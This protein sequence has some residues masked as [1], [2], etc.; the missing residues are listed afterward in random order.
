MILFAGFHIL[1]ILH[2]SYSSLSSKSCPADF[3]F[4]KDLP[5]FVSSLLSKNTLRSPA[6]YIQFFAK[7]LRFS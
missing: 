6:K 4:N 1:Q 2:I 5:P 7:N 3:W